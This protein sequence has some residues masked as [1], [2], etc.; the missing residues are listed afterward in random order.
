M[1]RTISL[2]KVGRKTRDPIYARAWW[3]LFENPIAHQ[4][5]GGG[6]VKG[7]NRIEEF[8]RNERC[9]TIPVANEVRR[10]AV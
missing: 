1:K 8:W 9:M 3:E 4:E 5:W 6:A 2:V 7:F 10:R